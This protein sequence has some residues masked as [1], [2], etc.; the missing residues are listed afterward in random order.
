MLSSSAV[1]TAHAAISFSTLFVESLGL[2]S[3]LGYSRDGAAQR[4]P[5]TDT[6]SVYYIRRER[7]D[8]HHVANVYDS[9]GVKLYTIE[10]GTMFTPVWSIVSAEERKEIGTLHAGLLNRYF[11]FNNKTDLKH[12]DIGWSL[13]SNGATRQFHLN[14]GAA[15][16]WRQGS[17]FLERIINPGG[18]DEEIHQRVAKARQLRTMRFDFEILVDET[19]IDRD[20]AIATAYISIMTQWGIGSYVDT[21]GPTVVK[22]KTEAD[23]D[24][25]SAF[26]F[27][28]Q[29]VEVIYSDDFGADDESVQEIDRNI[30]EQTPTAEPIAP[31]NL[32][33]IEPKMATSAEEPVSNVEAQDEEVEPRKVSEPLQI[34]EA[35]ATQDEVPFELR[36]IME[37]GVYGGELN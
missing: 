32:L 20:V 13:G 28:P 18:G 33:Q 29:F 12:R 6:P 25:P 4:T 11:D 31:E 3:F 21:R 27:D 34:E 35:K 1:F 17:R 7:T 16:E 19:M 24:I 9:S 22:T 5:F 14:D 26:S 15:Y 10:R 30:H 37:A 8:R 36:L 2:R 23:A